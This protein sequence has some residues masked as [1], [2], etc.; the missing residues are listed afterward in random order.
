MLPVIAIWALI[1]GAAVISG[2]MILQS[3]IVVI[4]TL[5]LTITAYKRDFRSSLIIIAATVVLCVLAWAIYGV[6]I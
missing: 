1:C 4:G 3:I 5:A 2:F 6:L